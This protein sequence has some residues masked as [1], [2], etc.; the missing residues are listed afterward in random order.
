[1]SSLDSASIWA[2]C[3]PPCRPSGPNLSWLCAPSVRPQGPLWSQ[4]GWVW[5]QVPCVHEC[6]G[7]VLTPKH[8]QVEQ[9]L[10][11]LLC[12]STMVAQFVTV[13]L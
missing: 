9:S 7:T 4:S 2:T 11:Q 1:M 5:V 10:E 12:P 13:F 8:H 3:G 6:H